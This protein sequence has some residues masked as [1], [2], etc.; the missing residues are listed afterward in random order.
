[1][2]PGIAIYY[3]VEIAMAPLLLSDK[4]NIASVAGTSLEASGRRWTLIRSTGMIYLQS[5][6]LG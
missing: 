2:K 1:M 6:T 4:V 5:S 3:S